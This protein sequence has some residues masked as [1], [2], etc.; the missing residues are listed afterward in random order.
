MCVRTLWLAVFLT[1]TAANSARAAEVA[2]F[3]VVGTNLSDGEMAAIGSLLASAYSAQTHKPVLGP[4]DLMPS[5][6]RTGS[7]RDTAQELGLT[8]YI[9]VEAV[10][11]TSRVTLH[12]S[13][14]NKHGTEL[15][16]VHATAMSLDD[17]EIV[18]ERIAA[19]LWRRTP[20]ENTR[21]IDNVTGKE[22]RAPNRLFLEKIF[23]GRFAMVL[24]V[25]YHLD[26]QPTMLIQFD[27]RL[28]QQDYFLELGL[29]FMVPNEIA[30]Q[31]SIAGLVGELGG[32]YYLSHASVSPYIGA[33][34]SPRIFFGMYEGV[35]MAVN[36]HVGLMFLRESSTRVYVEFQVDQNLISAN[37]VSSYF[38]SYSS[39]GGGVPRK[40]VLPTEFSLAVGMG[41]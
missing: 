34:L 28:E 24:P 3:P 26:A 30:R 12:A 40:S 37:P 38:Y 32:S 6:V 36:S 22:A 15:F 5:L 19:A 4:M 17:M 1:L 18:A 25:G 2:V 41:F 14:R 31:R 11:L 10:R 7:E 21:T 8:E 16:Q 9:H 33:G 29:G 13:L 23:G 20:L 39:S 27:T 35:G